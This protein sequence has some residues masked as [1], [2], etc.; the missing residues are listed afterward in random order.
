MAAITPQLIDLTGLE[1]FTL[2]A[3]SG[4]GDTFVNPTDGTT[5][6]VVDNGGGGAVVVTIDSLKASDFGT[7]EDIVVSVAAGARTFIGP[8]DRARFNDVAQTVGVT[9]DGVTSVTVAALKVDGRG[10]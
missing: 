1:D 10:W 4:G 8:F 5:L 9:Y 7:D 6:L 2:A 3:A